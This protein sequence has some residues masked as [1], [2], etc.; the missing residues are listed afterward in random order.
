LTYF[1]SACKFGFSSRS[2]TTGRVIR[3]VEAEARGKGVFPS[4]AS[5]LRKKKK[6][7]RLPNGKSDYTV[8]PQ[9]PSKEPEPPQP[10]TTGNAAA[11]GTRSNG[12]ILVRYLDHVVYSRTS[13]FAMKPQVREAVGWLVYECDQYVTLAWDR[14]AEPPALKGSDPKASGLVLLKSDIL[15]LKRIG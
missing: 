5:L 10:D 3:V 15:E 4:H 1:S 6:R 9:R 11:L 8:R 13:A 2:E 12:L 7:H 14:D